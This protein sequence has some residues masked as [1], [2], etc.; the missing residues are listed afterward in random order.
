MKYFYATRGAFTMC[1]W[2]KM[3]KYLMRVF[4]TCV[5]CVLKKKVIYTK[6]KNLKIYMISQI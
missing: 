4:V 5:L 3:K 1:Q 2:S 6:N